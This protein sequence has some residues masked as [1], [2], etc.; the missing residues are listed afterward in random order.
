MIGGDKATLHISGKETKNYMLN[1]SKELVREIE[2]KGEK[3][4]HRERLRVW[5]DRTGLFAAARPNSKFRKK[6]AAEEKPTESAVA[7]PQSKVPQE[8]TDKILMLHSKGQPARVIKRLFEEET[9]FNWNDVPDK[10]KKQI[11]EMPGP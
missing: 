2:A 1:L 5:I 6:E 8:E 3:L 7:E 4:Q 10:V 9:D 11:G